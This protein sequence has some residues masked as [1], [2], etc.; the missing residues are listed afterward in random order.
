MEVTRGDAPDATNWLKVLDLLQ[1]DF[2]EGW[3][4]EEVTWKNI[5]L[6]PKENGKFW[7]VNLVE[8]IWKMAMVI[9]NFCLRMDITFHD[10]LHGFR[11][12]IGV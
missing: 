11:S 10:V 12:G 9:L 7:G 6:T 8:F 4:E 2:R 5:N 1:T 3:M